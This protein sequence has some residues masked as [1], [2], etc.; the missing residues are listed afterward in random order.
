MHR[1]QDVFKDSKIDMESFTR[2]RLL[3]GDDAFE[4][5]QTK[6]VGVFGLGG[7]G[8][9]AC[10]ALSRSGISKLILFDFDRVQQ[11]NMNRLTIADGRD[12]GR[13]K[14][15]VMMSRILSFNPNAEI[16]T[17]NEFIDKDAYDAV[18]AEE[19]PDF[20]VDAV[21]S[22]RPKIE[23][24][25]RLVSA[26]ARFISSMGAGGRFDPSKVRI[27]SLDEV[28]GCGLASRIRR[29]LRNS[30]I[31]TEKIKTVYSEE[32]P[33][34]PLPPE[35]DAVSERGRTRGTQSSCMM[36]PVTFGMNIAS[37]VIR[38]LLRKP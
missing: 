29:V 23:T 9:A 2:I 5:L 13:M 24:I 31:Y 35:K 32:H 10:D 15:E 25:M 14:T 8:G 27:G 17:F 3:I 20:C 21:D 34:K 26:K 37:F 18:I 22:L 30:G 6:K 11:S 4:K 33:V 16:K 7:V 28:G 1:W 12:I 19:K 38:E 36:V